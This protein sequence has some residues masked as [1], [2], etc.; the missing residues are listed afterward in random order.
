MG[1]N[2]NIAVTLLITG[3]VV[4][5]AV[6]IMLIGII[7]IYSA[8]VNSA[9]NM[10]KKKKEAQKAVKATDVAVSAP[11]A[12]VAPVVAQPVVED[13]LEVIA[14]ISAA[15][16]AMY[17][18]ENVKITSVKKSTRNRPVWSTAGLIDNTRPF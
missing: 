18:T 4:V 12:P 13:S 9:E 14:V 16:Q 5:F 17:G 6:L 2:I 3:F 11:V 10:A 15:V 1:E 8:V 7:K